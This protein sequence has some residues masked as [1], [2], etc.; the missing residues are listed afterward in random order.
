MSD[1]Q[2]ALGVADPVLSISRYRAEKAREKDEENRRR[3]EEQEE[4]QNW[5]RTQT[6][7]MALAV[8]VPAGLALPALVDR[9]LAGWLIGQIPILR[10]LEGNTGAEFLAQIVLIVLGGVFV[11]FFAVLA[12]PR[13]RREVCLWLNGRRRKGRGSGP[14]HPSKDPNR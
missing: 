10:P 14:E 5:Q 7:L 9:D 8:V 2:Y 13:W 11:G 12:I 6:L 3:K 1:G 4:A